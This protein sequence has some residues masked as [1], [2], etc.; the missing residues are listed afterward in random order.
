M[1]LINF[2]NPLLDLFLQDMSKEMAKQPLSPYFDYLLNKEE[3]RKRLRKWVEIVFKSLEGKEQRDALLDDQKR[4]GAIR[5]AEGVDISNVYFLYSSIQKFVYKQLREKKRG[6]LSN[7]NLLKLYRESLTFNGILQNSFAMHASIF[8]KTRESII[9][10]KASQLQKL[11]SYSLA[12]IQTFKMEDIARM[13]LERLRDIIKADKFYL[14]IHNKLQPEKP[15][16]YPQSLKNHSL[17]SLMKHTSEEGA[18][19]FVDGMGLRHR[20]INWAKDLS[21]AS[22]PII[23]HGKCHGAITFTR[24]SKLKTF[25]L[26]PMIF[27]F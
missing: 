24:G 2:L 25:S 15:F 8:V 12:L 20:D 18:P 19:F 7:A 4:F 14:M 17:L 10:K 13:T 27:S 9:D 6:D 21:H 11:H 3:G 26:P 5:A 23:A 16:Y 1:L 22:I